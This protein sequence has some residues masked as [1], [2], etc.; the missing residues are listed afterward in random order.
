MTSSDPLT[1]KIQ[2]FSA[3]AHCANFYNFLLFGG[4]DVQNH[5]GGCFTP[6]ISVVWFHNILPFFGHVVCKWSICFIIAC[7]SF[8]FN[9]TQCVYTQCPN[10]LLSLLFEDSFSFLKFFEKI[11][12][13]GCGT[14]AWKT[15]SKRQTCHVSQV[16]FVWWCSLVFLFIVTHPTSLFNSFAMQKPYKTKNGVLVCCRDLIFKLFYLFVYSQPCS[17]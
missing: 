9:L 6:S 3:I 16:S 13:S 5:V 7:L 17:Q 4:Y 8:F 1:V 15:K 14:K 11:R 10:F 2:K 12:W